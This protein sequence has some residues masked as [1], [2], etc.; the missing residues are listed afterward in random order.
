MCPV[1][2]RAT[3]KTKTEEEEG[4]G[5]CQGLNGILK[6]SRW[7]LDWDEE[8]RDKGIK[9]TLK[10]H[11]EVSSLTEHT[12]IILHSLLFHDLPFMLPDP[13]LNTK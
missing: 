6:G 11:E 3:K 2:F 12:E 8:L 10:H 1:G 4:Q 13:S 9:E 5:R 7:W